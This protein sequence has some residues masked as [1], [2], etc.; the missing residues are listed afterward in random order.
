MD[1]RQICA[2]FWWPGCDDYS[3]ISLTKRMFRPN[4]FY[5]T[6]NFAH[7]LAPIEKKAISRTMNSGDI[8]NLSGCCKKHGATAITDS[9]K[10]PNAI[11]N[12]SALFSI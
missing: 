4:L 7:I 11:K 1:T 3:F 5:C 2:V 12:V 9:E 6:N 10:G 8:H